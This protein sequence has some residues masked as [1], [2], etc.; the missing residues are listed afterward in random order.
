VAA[1]GGTGACACVR[2]HCP[3]F[4]CPAVLSV[5][6]QTAV[7]AANKVHILLC[8]GCCSQGLISP[9]AATPKPAAPWSQAGTATSSSSSLPASV[10]Q[11]PHHS[12]SH[13]RVEPDLREQIARHLAAESLHAAQP[14]PP[15]AADAMTPTAPAG[16]RPVAAAG[17]NSA[18]SPAGSSS[19][20]SQQDSPR[21][22]GGKRSSVDF[23]SPS[24]RKA[25]PS[26]TQLRAVR[27]LFPISAPSLKPAAALQVCASH[28]C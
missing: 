20:G 23:R 17:V 10:Q 15:A 28:E 8:L 4:P 21:G 18:T 19:K 3:A 11:H 27:K 6:Q 14:A 2:T 24:P 13:K 12:S 7:A 1:V 9:K 16:D 26:R 22:R 5:V 25:G